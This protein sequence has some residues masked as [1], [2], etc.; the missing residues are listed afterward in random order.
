[1]IKDLSELQKFLKLCRKHG[2]KEIKYGDCAVTFGDLPH[3]QEPE[4]DSA[5]IP[6]EELTPE[7]MMFFSVGGSP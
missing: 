7:Q 3:R 5:E 2:I 4:D 1:M 6:T